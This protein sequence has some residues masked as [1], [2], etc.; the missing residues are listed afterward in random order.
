MPPLLSWVRR[1]LSILFLVQTAQVAAVCLSNQS[2]A[3]LE[4]KR[5]L[6]LPQPDPLISWSNGNNCCSWHGVVCDPSSTG[7]VISL[8]LSA[9]TAS[10]PSARTLTKSS[11]FSDA[12]FDLRRL[13]VLDLSYNQFDGSIPSRLV[14]LTELTHLNLSN[15][16]FSGQVPQEISRMTWL[17]SLDLS[18]SYLSS[19]FLKLEKPSFVDLFKNLGKLEVLRLDGMNISMSGAECSSVLASSLPNLRNLSLSSCSIIGPMN[20]SIL[21]IRSSLAH[22]DLSRNNM[23]NVP[24]FFTDLTS[25]GYLGLSSCSLQGV[26]PAGIF[27]LPYLQHLDISNNPNLQ[28]PFPEILSTGRRL[29]TLSLSST[30]LSG[31]IPDSIGNLPEL[32]VLK[33]SNCNFTGSIPPSLSGLTRLQIIDMS[34][35]GFN[36]SLPFLNASTITEVDLSMNRLSGS[37]PKSFRGLHGLTTL[38]LDH[39]LLIGPIPAPL[40]NLPSLK[41]VDLSNNN[42]TGSLSQ[43]T[44]SSSL[45]ETLDLSN[46]SLTGE[47]PPSIGSLSQFK[48][49]SLSS[50]DFSGTINISLFMGMKNLSK[51]HLSGNRLT[52][53]NGDHRP[54]GEVARLTSL[55]L[56]SCNIGSSFLD[57]I[58]QQS[59]LTILDLG[60]NTM[61]GA[62]P[63][64]LWKVR[65]LQY[66]NLSYNMLTSLENPMDVGNM[67]SLVMLDLHSNLLGPD[68]PPFPPKAIFL[69]FSSNNFS[70]SIPSSINSTSL[71]YLSISNNRI[72]G[73]ITE[74]LCK[75]AV[76][77]VLDLS[78]NSLVGSIPS[79]LTNSSGLSVLNL[80]E[81]NLA[82]SIPDGF[83]A[84]CSLRTLNLK[85]NRLSGKLPE[86]LCNCTS[87]EVLDLSNNNVTDEFP[88]HLLHCLKN[89]RVLALRSNQLHG[90]IVAPKE[91]GAFSLLQ[92]FDISCNK[93]SGI[94]QPPFFKLLTAMM[95]KGG[96]GTAKLLGFS[97]LANVYY[98]DTVATTIKGV[99]F[100]MVKIVTALTSIDLSNNLFYGTI[101]AEIGKLAGLVILNMSRNHISGSIPKA[102]GDLLLLE[103][104]DL[105]HNNL[106]GNIPPELTKLTFLSVLNLSFNNLSGAIPE[107]NQFSTFDASSFVGNPELCG[108]QINKSCRNDGRTG[109]RMAIAGKGVKME[110][111][112]PGLGF[113]A[114][115]AMFSIPVLFMT[116]KRK[117][118]FDHV[119]R[120]IVALLFVPVHWFCGKIKGEGAVEDNDFDDSDEDV[121]EHGEKVESMS[122]TDRHFCV[123]CTKLEHGATR[124]VHTECS[125]LAN[126]NVLL[127]PP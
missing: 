105:S 1:F 39:N 34:F 94:I 48:V 50:N 101:P 12:L 27:G 125:C 11:N 3:L 107:G 65:N 20:E 9:V 83:N 84:E 85:G 98:Q 56:S 99:D 53:A 71:L 104:L 58:R 118:Y 18:V 14:E 16:G 2:A 57:S 120:V 87:L 90:S 28:G 89:L 103:S 30:N 96:N 67:T 78:N 8:Q 93:L 47:I 32:R 121:S 126:D 72:T 42:L 21:S 109:G 92:I 61:S 7:F 52:V 115:M 86:G 23:S 15:A 55:Q 117:W 80:R 4:F 79:C 62:I 111:I 76:L 43:F 81:N 91:G 82:N 60:N 73:N 88:T 36:G 66:L 29:L 35:N 110:Y 97:F 51:L 40:L 68:L 25:L 74:S 26:F 119:D 113:G 63:S 59:N 69:D 114:G 13:Q 127:H 33:M 102:M 77:T 5:G 70:S 44:N 22:L 31:N 49:I 38:R 19:A 123:F 54:Q 122:D 46:N 24:E 116:E 124:A 10:L 108:L 6:A 17:V 41:T 37:I 95:K 45:L 112:A 100:Q 106:T 64:W 75:S